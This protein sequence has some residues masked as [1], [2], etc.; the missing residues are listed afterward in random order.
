[1]RAG[2]LVLTG[3]RVKP[4]LDANPTIISAHWADLMAI[5]FPAGTVTVGETL[6]VKVTVCRTAS[7][8][9]TDPSAVGVV[10]G[11][12]E[13]PPA[14]AAPKARRRPGRRPID[15]TPVEEVVAER[16]RD[17]TR[18]AL[19]KDE[20]NAIFALARRRYPSAQLPTVGSIEDHVT[21]L[22][23]RVSAAASPQ[24]PDN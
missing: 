13:Q 4:S 3:L 2:E 22:Y 9:A 11:E 15:W 6:F 8:T 19:V 14:E 10:A 17:G 16:N 24:N 1:V 18:L 21:E 23:E 12:A 20:A 7:S 5:N